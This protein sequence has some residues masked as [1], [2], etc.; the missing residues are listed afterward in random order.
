MSNAMQKKQNNATSFAR[1][2]FPEGLAQ[3]F[4]MKSNLYHTRAHRPLGTM[5]KF[6]FIAEIKPRS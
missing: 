6:T 2:P 4:R 1:N 5:L 3:F